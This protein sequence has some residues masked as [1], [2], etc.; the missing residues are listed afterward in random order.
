MGVIGAFVMIPIF[1]I[2][3][4][5]NAIIAHFTAVPAI[6]VWQASLLYIAMACIAYLSGLVQIEFRAETVE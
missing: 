4:F 5:W 3:V 2:N 1:C 6:A